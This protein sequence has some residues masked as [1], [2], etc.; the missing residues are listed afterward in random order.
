MASSKDGYRIN[1]RKKKDQE[2]IAFIEKC[3]ALQC[4]LV[5]LICQVK[6]TSLKGRLIIILIERRMRND[7]Q[8]EKIIF[9]QVLRK[10]EVKEYK[11][12]K[13]I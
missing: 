5:C 12:G 13:N 11:N 1:I 3:I 10:D 7:E 9:I 6:K 8:R 4:D 2:K